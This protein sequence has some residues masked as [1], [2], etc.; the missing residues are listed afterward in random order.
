VPPEA[1]RE[2]ATLAARGMQLQITVQEGQIWV[3]NGQHS[4]AL[5]P[6]ALQRPTTR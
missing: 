4:V 1:S 2:L 5:E 3:G 6:V